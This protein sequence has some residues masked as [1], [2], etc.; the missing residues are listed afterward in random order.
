MIIERVEAPTDEVR[1]LIGELDAELA[2]TYTPE[3]RHV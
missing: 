2:G 3:Q 1:A